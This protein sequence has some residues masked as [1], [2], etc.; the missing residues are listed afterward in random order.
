MSLP[1]ALGLAA[2]VSANA[3]NATTAVACSPA[4][5]S[6]SSNQ[7]SGGSRIVGDWQASSAVSLPASKPPALREGVDLGLAPGST[8]LDRMI[9]LLEPSAAQRVALDGELVAQQTPGSCEY[10]HWLTP[11]QFA[12][13]YANSVADVN[14]VAS[15]LGAQGFTVAPIP[16]SRGWIEFSGT[17]AQVTQTF[18]AQIHAYSTA[19]GTRYA[20]RSAVSVPAALSPVIHGLVSL[21]GSRSAAAIT[22]PL[23]MTTSAAA[24]AEETDASRAEALTPQLAAQAMHFDGMPQ[25][26]GESIAIAAR[27]NIEAQ[28]VASFRSTFGLTANP[29][30]VALAGADPGMNSDRAAIELAASWAG[31][32]APSARVLVVPAGSTAATDGVDLALTAIVQQS[33]AHTMLVGYTACEAALSESHQA[34]YAAL[35]RQASAQGISAIAATGDSGAAACH[36]AGVNVPVTTGYSV[37]AL[38]ATPWNT[39]VGAAA[40]GVSG[41]TEFAAWSP[42]NAAEPSYATG[43]G[44]SATYAAPV[45]QVGL[46]GNSS[47]SLPDLSF[48]TAVDSALSRGLAFCFSGS[49]SSSG[50]SL[51]RAGGSGAAAAILAGVSAAI[52]QQDGPQGNLAPRLYALRSRE[53][54]FSDVQT[55]NARLACAAGTQGCD[56][57]G[58]LGYGAEDGF[59][60]ASGLGVPD[61]VELLKAWPQVGSATSIVNLS[62]SPTEPNQTYNPQAAITLTATITGGAG[63]PTGTVDFF[64]QKTN[65]NL[66]SSTLDSTGVAAL[67]LQ[68]N[69]PQGGNT[70]IAKYLGDSNYAANNSSALTINIQPSTTTT[71]VTP[72][73]TTPKVGTAFTVKATIAVGS[74]P[75]GAVTPTGNVTLT[76]D[77]LNYAIS[78]ATTSGGV[79]TASFNVTISSTGS[80][81]LQAVY[82]GDSNYDNST[83]SAVAVNVASNTAGV[84]LA[85]SPVQGTYNPSASL[86]FTATVA[87]QSGGATPTGTVTFVNTS[88]GHNLGTNPAQ[89]SGSGVA[90]LTVSS[91]FAVGS[92]AIVAQ[93]SGDT[94]YGSANSKATTVNMALSSTTTTVTPS[95]L[96]PRVNVAF[97]VTAALTVGSPTAGTQSPSGNI[98]LTIDGTSYASVAVSTSGGTTSA[99][100]TGVKVTTPGNHSLQAVYAGD[101]NYATSTSTALAVNAAANTASVTLSVAPTQPNATYNPSA[102]IVFTATVIST[103]GGST[104][105]G[106][107]N[108][109]DQAT[110][111]N[112]NTSAVALDSSGKASITVTGG[113]PQG[114]NAI[115]AKYAGDG[116]YPAT[117]SQALTVNIQPSTTTTTVTPSTTTPPAGVAFPVTVTVAVGSPPAGTAPPTGKINLNLDGLAYASADASTTGG[118]TSATF[119]VSLPAGGSHNLQA[120]YGGD[121]NYSDSTSAAVAVNAT[122]GATVTTLTATPTTFSPGTAESFTA[123]IAAASG[124]STKDTFTGT[125]TFFDNT[126]Q[127]GT[128][129]VASNGATLSDVN[130][131]GTSTHVITAVYSGDDSWAGS[132]SNAITL[133]PILIP[134]ITTL[135]VSPATAEPGQVVTLIATVK[136]T[137]A[138]ATSVEQNPTGDVVFYNGTTV[139][140]TVALTAAAN[141]TATAQLLYSTLPAGQNSLSAV[142]VGDLFYAASTSNTITITVQDF[143]LTPDPGNPPSDLDIIKGTSGSFAFQVT[144]QG[145][146]NAPV[147]ITCAVP[148]TVYMT[149]VPNV[150]T[151]TPNGTVTFVVNT[152]LTGGL[153]AGSNTP[154]HLWP[155]AAAGTALAALL[156]FLLP[157]GQRVRIFS[158]RGRRML[159]LLLLLGSLGAAG[160]GCS[161]TSG[162]STGGSDGTPLGETTLKITAAANVDNTVFSHTAFINVNVLPP[163]STSTSRPVVG[164]K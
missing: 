114:G 129:T 38:A 139:L 90:T 32:A 53:G 110:G 164:S 45:W 13:A 5:A 57:S 156:F 94:D 39:A 118:K 125:V 111:S 24:L 135:A 47:R 65:S 12:S 99:T 17:A 18:G 22:T 113:M 95:T 33:R 91:G 145:G 92:N 29:V 131:S 117:N 4:P 85:V 76:V 70:I 150:L 79:T 72:S 98:T 68:G 81:N 25:G 30:G 88:T 3:Q 102:A 143:T 49:T 83:S 67:A 55:G 144:G 42:V 37:N 1:L 107:V 136:P 80:H 119:S 8:R 86:T 73:T 153:K 74:P 151:V 109:L 14:V 44:R 123:T 26:A 100:F 71:T 28:D 142:Y 146:F 36:A 122:K 43:G 19:T 97:S 77:G 149:C 23:S 66:G 31:A 54:V 163:G 64:D 124:S 120:I 106:D 140:A 9:L 159:I 130:L 62:V 89:L 75:A 162:G 84:T 69:M 137:T 128:A 93:Y 7:G 127:L 148:A 2:G 157:C 15:W 134:T 96:T 87:S 126:G 78:A 108:F 63:T 103:S 41:A 161:S 52:A 40:F 133:K 20:L 6:V 160:M 105:T 51:V 16:T 141:N 58:T 50:C 101:S 21:D 34:F 46:S 132:T 154:P 35:Y 61:P 152:F 158:E 60:L 155:H 10:H 11:Q 48:P 147:A 59:D 112:L 27:S 138:P 82:A 121:N 115:I 116:T 104:P 56:A